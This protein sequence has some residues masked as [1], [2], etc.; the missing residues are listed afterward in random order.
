MSF[1]DFFVLL[2]CILFVFIWLMSDTNRPCVGIQKQ[3]HCFIENQSQLIFTLN[4]KWASWKF[5][6]IL[7]T[8]FFIAQKI[9]RPLSF[10]IELESLMNEQ[11]SLAVAW[12]GL[13]WNGLRK[14]IFFIEVWAWRL[15]NPALGLSPFNKCWNACY[16]TGVR[17]KVFH[18][19][20]QIA[21]SIHTL[22]QGKIKLFEQGLASPWRCIK[23]GR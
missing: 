22:S 16:I 20:G 15:G 10:V 1:K 21:D 3:L 17:F 6:S 8:R 23:R 12:A 7:D 5:I 19:S 11:T 2:N 13:F 18:I 4:G 9:D 14:V